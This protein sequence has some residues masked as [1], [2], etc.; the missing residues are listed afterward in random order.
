MTVIAE[1]GI[2][3]TQP[4]ISPWP[5]AV[6][7]NCPAFVRLDNGISVLVL[8]Q[9]EVN[10]RTAL[11]RRAA[12]GYRLGSGTLRLVG[13]AR[14]TADDF[15]DDHRLATLLAELPPFDP[16]THSN[17][18]DDGRPLLPGADSVWLPF[19]WAYQDRNGGT[20]DL[21]VLPDPDLWADMIAGW[22]LR[23]ARRLSKLV[24]DDGTGRPPL[25]RTASALAVIQ[26]RM[27][28]AVTDFSACLAP[29]LVAAVRCAPK[30]VW[31]LYDFCLADGDASHRQHR[32]QAIATYPLLADA[33]CADDGLR[34]VIDDARPLASAL[35]HRFRCPAAA[36]RALV[37]L[38]ADQVSGGPV[39][40]AG[41]LLAALSHCPPN[42]R[43]RTPEQWRAFLELAHI[44]DQVVP[45]T[46]T[47]ERLRE[48]G[49]DWAESRSL[50]GPFERLAD[51]HD[52]RDSLRAH[53]LEAPFAGA[54]G[55]W[56]NGGASPATQDLIPS[57]LH[58]LLDS[59]P[60]LEQLAASEQWHLRHDH[61]LAAIGTAGR[62]RWL[63]WPALSAPHHTGNGLTI[64]P[65]VNSDELAQEGKAMGH[66]VAGYD[67]HCAYMQSHIV[68]IRTASGERLSTAELHLGE[69]GAISMVQH[70]GRSNMPPSTT[71]V[72]ALA[73]YLDAIASRVVRVDARRL[74]EDLDWRQRR[75][76]SDTHVGFDPAD[77]AALERVFEVYR[78]L[79]PKPWQ[80]MN[81]ATFHRESGLAS[82]ISE[83]CRNTPAQRQPMVLPIPMRRAP[84]ETD[85]EELRREWAALLDPPPAP[86]M[87]DILASIRRVLR[88]G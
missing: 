68:S 43:P 84:V 56:G 62:G 31:T 74:A 38:G 78:P 85:E 67:W 16:V 26:V 44:P 17:D 37:G 53:V 8:R 63:S 66:C 65:L 87:E 48:L 88:D 61:L 14:I 33:L 82:A 30:P 5:T 75:R 18:S 45:E 23:I 6:A 1:T 47:I 77:E 52:F 22:C 7:L 76:D 70:R 69:D 60:L 54:A 59:R 51:I 24:A 12:M 21:S 9:A 71:A 32:T 57:L 15:T 27:E 50:I 11:V 35:R 42:W 25:M 80:R 86:R 46:W 20:L 49:P 64:I 10:S 73:E 72:N 79:L 81:M 29:E 2:T 83:E 41:R 58:T 28:A 13:T 4:A 3:S 34:T 55:N 36:I 39:P 40:P 19:D